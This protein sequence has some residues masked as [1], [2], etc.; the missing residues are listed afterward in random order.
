MHRSLRLIARVVECFFLVPTR[1][2]GAI[3]IA[4]MGL[5]FGLA[6]IDFP[7]RR[8]GTFGLGLTIF[9]TVHTVPEI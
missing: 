6:F 9:Q 4:L 8:K 7:Q 1:A 3:V 5:T 2:V